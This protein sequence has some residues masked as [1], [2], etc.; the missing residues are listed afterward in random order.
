MISISDILLPAHV[1]LALTSKDQASGVEEVLSKLNGDARIKNWD[2]LHASV[3]ERN[4]PAL[5]C[6][7]CGVCIAHGRTNAVDSLVMA[8]GRSAAGLSSPQIND[9]VR[10]V[11]VAGI[12]SAFDSEYL[13]LVGALARICR[14]KNLL[15][16]LLGVA[17]P[18]RFVELLVSGE[19]KL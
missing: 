4:A 9:R 10:L 5:S 19:A 15:D 12:P 2:G 8:A 16:K 17:D 3:L 6:N 13:R 11:F 18:A 7:E 14:D 1:N